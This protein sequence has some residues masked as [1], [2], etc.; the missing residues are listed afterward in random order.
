MT[1]ETKS[2]I[3]VIIGPDAVAGSIL[4]RFKKIGTRTPIDAEIN[5]LKNVETPTT[6]AMLK[7]D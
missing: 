4:T 3:V 7:A 5:I 6:K 1:S 2:L